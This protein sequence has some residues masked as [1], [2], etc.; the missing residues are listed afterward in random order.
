MVFGEDGRVKVVERSLGKV[1]VVQ[2][3]CA[4]ASHEECVLDRVEYAV[5]TLARILDIGKRWPMTPVDMTR[6]ELASDGSGERQLST[7]E[8]ILLASSRPSLPVT[9]LAQPELM[10]MARIPSP[11]RAS[12]VFRLTVTGAAWN[13]FLVKT[14]AAEHGA[15]EA[16]NARSGKRVFDAFTPT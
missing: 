10:T 16:I 2:M 6:V 4:V 1:S 5:G 9:A 12:R 7:A 15:S 14:A 11:L 3:E 13:L 8:A